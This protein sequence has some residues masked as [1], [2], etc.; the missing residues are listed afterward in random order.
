MSRK[1][2]SAE[3]SNHATT[4]RNYS[5]TN[6]SKSH[7]E[8]SLFITY[9]LWLVGGI[10]GI[11]HFYLGRDIQGFLWW[12]TLG[13]YFG[14]GWLRDIFHIQNYVAD[15]N[16]D[17]DYLDKFNHNLRSYKY[18]SIY[19]VMKFSVLLYICKSAVDLAKSANFKLDRY[20]YYKYLY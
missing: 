4:S 13:G 7:A 14:F 17:R 19:T 11:H 15:A 6:K 20:R 5:S 8:K 16:K 2:N 18:V 3:P 9:F 12:C 10:F 1:H